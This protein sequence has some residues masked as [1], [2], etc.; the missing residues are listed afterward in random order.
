MQHPIIP[1]VLLGLCTLFCILLVLHGLRRTLERSG[2]DPS[3]QFRVY[4]NPLLELVGWLLLLGAP[5]LRGFFADFSKVPPRIG[6]AMMLPLPFVLWIAFSKKGRE[7]LL[8][9]PLQWPIYLQSF[10]I[11]VEIALWLSV[12][13]G[14]LPVQMSF[15]GRNFD[16]LTGLFALPAGYFYRVKRVAL[17]FNIFGLL[18]LINI[19]VIAVLSMPTPL[20]AFHN[21]PANTLVAYF[22]FIYLPTVLV[23]LAFTLHIFSLRQ[24]KLVRAGRQI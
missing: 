6:P 7:L 15:E 1:A 3:R 22:P 5:S 17:V 20:R 18:S 2:W 13:D 12:R 14:A 4:R 23:P 9:M 11:V 16:I 8:R 19:V 21:E 10:R 24:L